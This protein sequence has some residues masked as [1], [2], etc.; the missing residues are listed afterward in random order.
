[1]E[2]GCEEGYYL[3]TTRKWK[4]YVAVDAVHLKVDFGDDRNFKKDSVLN[5]PEYEDKFDVS[6]KSWAFNVKYGLQCQMKRFVFDVSTGMGV[7][8]RKVVRSGFNET[9]DYEKKPRHPNAYYNVSKEGSFTTLS[10]PFN[11]R[12]GYRF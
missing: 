6:K 10:V 7:E 4:G 8:Y 12:V 3:N 11:I 2:I 1:V 9:G 5:T